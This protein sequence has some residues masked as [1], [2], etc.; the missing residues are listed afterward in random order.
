MPARFVLKVIERS[1]PP[2]SMATIMA[3]ASTPNS[4]NWKAIC[5]MLVRLRNFEGCRMA[6]TANTTTKAMM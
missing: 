1:M 3:R 5:W 2:L 6:R 4:G